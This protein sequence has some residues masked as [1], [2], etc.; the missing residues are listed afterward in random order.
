[1]IVVV[2]PGAGVPQPCSEWCASECAPLPCRGTTG[3][4]PA[5]LL[6]LDPAHS[7]RARGGFG[8]LQSDSTESG[9][10]ARSKRRPPGINRRHGT[11]ARVGESVWWWCCRDG[12]VR[13][14][15]A[16]VVFEV[17]R[18]MAVWGWVCGPRWCRG[19]DFAAPDTPGSRRWRAPAKHLTRRGQPPQSC[20]AWSN[21]CGVSANHRSTALTWQGS[22]S[23]V[24][25]AASD[26]RAVRVAGCGWDSAMDRAVVTTGATMA[27]LATMGTSV[28]GE[29]NG[30]KD[31]GNFRG[32]SVGA[33]TAPRS[34]LGRRR[35]GRKYWVR[36][37]R[38]GAAG[39]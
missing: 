33:E 35:A 16:V 30:R 29:R 9:F 27:V 17:G 2:D 11:G 4:A 7:G 6:P 10:C 34:A 12:C 31:T 19:E 22:R 3:T 26:R 1:M 37:R 36:R 13:L 25:S 28:R 18:C 23:S 5:G 15:I 14:V 21:S 39:F 20:L 38:R 8:H 32:G 24:L